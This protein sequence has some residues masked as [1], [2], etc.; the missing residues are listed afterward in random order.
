[1]EELKTVRKWEQEIRKTERKKEIGEIN[2]T[3]KE[4]EQLK[5]SKW[6]KRGRKRNL[7]GKEKK[8][9]SERERWSRQIQREKA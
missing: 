7:F 5:R 4:Y 3:M 9:I 1:M 6:K 2:K 8:S